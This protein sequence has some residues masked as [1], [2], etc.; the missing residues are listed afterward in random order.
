MKHQIE[1][2]VYVPWGRGIFITFVI[3]YMKSLME[4]CVYVPWGREIM[5]RKCYDK[6]IPWHDGTNG[7]LAPLSGMALRAIPSSC[8]FFKTNHGKSSFLIGTPSI[9]EPFSMAML[10]NQRV[11]IR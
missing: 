3:P 11:N 6:E 5:T 2:C 7:L 8:G 4:V 1:V 10:N 9:N